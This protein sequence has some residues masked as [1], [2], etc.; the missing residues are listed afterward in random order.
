M[1]DQEILSQ[2]IDIAVKNGWDKRGADTVE[3][4]TETITLDFVDPSYS[5]TFASIW[6][7]TPRKAQEQAIDTYNVIYSHSFAKALW[8]DVPDYEL[9]CPKCDGRYNLWDKER[10]KEW[11]PPPKYCNADGMKL[12]KV[13]K[14][15][16]SRWWSHLRNMVVSNSP[17]EYLDEN[18][19]DQP[20]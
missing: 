18:M 16:A 3:V 11:G 17:L 9:A 15:T 13:T 12:K 14:G 8:P 10:A 1:T 2:A 4:R 5:E 20:Q 7:I 19:P 6:F